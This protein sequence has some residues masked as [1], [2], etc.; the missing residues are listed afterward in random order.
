MKLI[1]KA[2][3]PAVVALAGLA[4]VEAQ[5]A[6]TQAGTMLR[7]SASLSYD[8]NGTTQTPVTDNADVI[9]DV[10]VMFTLDATDALVN[11]TTNLYNLDGVATAQYYKVGEFNLANTGNTNTTFYLTLTDLNGVQVEGITATAID[12]IDLSNSGT[13]RLFRESGTTAGLSADDIEITTDTILVNAEGETNPVGTV[14]YVVARQDAVI[15]ENAD[16]L[17]VNL[18]ASAASVVTKGAWTAPTDT[19]PESYAADVTIPV[20]ATASNTNTGIQF[21]YADADGDNIE[22]AEDALQLGFPSFGTDPNDPTRQGFIKEAVVVYDPISGAR[23]DGNSPK[24]IPG[25]VVRYTLRLENIGSMAAE[26]VTIS[27][28]L[29]TATT[30]CTSSD[31]ALCTDAPAG[32]SGDTVT[33]DAGTLVYD[34]T[35]GTVKAVYTSFAQD[36]VANI[37]FY[38]LID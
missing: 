28:P 17:G 3:L 6:G 27:D 15:G 29:P 11:D 5:A 18:Q 32:I 38:V 8:V 13:Y 35:D 4:S 24:A 23:A 34:G 14:I 22:D 31:Y 16:V 37:V 19:T 21:V 25:A 36:G 1:Q 2:I 30:Y 10:K 7:N 9:V 20:E 26:D 12:S 33:A